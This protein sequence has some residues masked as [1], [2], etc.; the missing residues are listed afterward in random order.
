MLTTKYEDIVNVNDIATGKFKHPSEAISR[1]LQEKVE[2][3][4]KDGQRVLLIGIDWQNDFVIPGADMVQP[5]EPYGSLSVPGAKGD[6][7]R[8]TRFIYNNL[9][10]ITRIMLSV[11]THYP[12]QIFH[13]SMWRDA[14]GTPVS[15]YTPITSADLSSGKYKFVGGN[16][17]K[18]AD[19][20]KALENAGKGGVFVW[21]DHCIAGTP[22]WNL[23]TQLMQMVT[24]HSAVR[25]VDPIFA[26]KGTDRYSEMYGILEPEYNP[27]GI[28]TKQ[29]IDAI[30]SFDT[31]SGDI[32]E[33][34]WSK[35]IIGGE[36]GSHCLL[37]STKQIMKRFKGHPEIMGRIYVLEDCTS[38]VGGFEQQM[39]DAFAEFK[40]EGVNIV[41]ST[42]LTL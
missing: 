23:E 12:N 29:I 30:A 18:A 42:D 38:P 31:Q 26:F 20:V 15:P 3:A 11:D 41:K 24:F 2:P 35:I 40:R 39:I 5:G 22:G 28:V 37:E 6:I 16:P 34:K 1:A 21:P 14:N 4:N 9:D 13:R 25:N 32:A 8:W 17:K 7:E 19:C 36:A 33:M 27:N 10:K